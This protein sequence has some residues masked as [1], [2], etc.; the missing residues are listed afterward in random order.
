MLD[1]PLRMEKDREYIIDLI[2]RCV[3]GDI[4]A[5]DRLISSISPFISYA[6]EKKLQRTGSA[7]Q[8]ADI[9]NLKQD[10]LLSIWKDNKLKTIKDKKK[11]IPWIYTFAGNSVSD[12]LRGPEAKSKKFLPLGNALKSPESLPDDALSNREIQ[13]TFERAL[14]ALNP[15]ENIIIKLLLLY[16]KKHR[17]IAG[18]LDIPIGTVLVSAQRARLKLRREMKKFL[19][20]M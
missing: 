17:E 8:K 14:R 7:Y 11:I 2:E 16:G 13:E 19:K 5:W 4:E 12:Y 1:L 15:K 18:M 3:R 20:N 9:E 10:I 6:I